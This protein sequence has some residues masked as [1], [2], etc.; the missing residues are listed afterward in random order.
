MYKQMTS[1]LSFD[2]QQRFALDDVIIAR[3][4]Y[5]QMCVGIH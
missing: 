2:E 1:S 5:L 4:L 3:M